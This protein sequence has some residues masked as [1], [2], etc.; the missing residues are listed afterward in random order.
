MSKI[1]IKPLHQK[2]ADRIRE[3]IRKGLLKKGDRIIE[4][5]LCDSLGI[6]RT[7]LRE[8]LR[9]LSSEGL[10]DVIPN[11]GAHVA[12][13]SMRDVREMFEVMSILEGVCARVA[14]EK[15]TDGK[16]AK[17]EKLHQKLEKHFAEKDA[18]KYLNANQDYH[19]LVQEMAGNKVLDEVVNGLRQK[20]LLYRYRQLYQQ[21]RFNDSIKEHR[22]LLDAFRARDPEAAEHL[23]KQHLIKQCDALVSL[24]RDRGDEPE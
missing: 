19:V 16:F 5:E 22:L 7:P 4:T 11:K 18:E 14:A 24:Y 23:M 15:M 17:I 21:D 2:V 9:I 6:S 10:I 20:I 8:A 12:Q 3:L 13:P 1:T